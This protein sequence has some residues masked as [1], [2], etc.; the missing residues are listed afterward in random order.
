MDTDAQAEIAALKRKL[1]KLSERLGI[2]VDDSDENTIEEQVDEPAPQIARGT[3]DHTAEASTATA[4]LD[5]LPIPMPAP[6]PAP[7]QTEPLPDR[8]V[9]TLLRT[10]QMMTSKQL[11]NELHVPVEKVEVATRE[12]YPERLTNL[13]TVQHPRWYLRLGEECSPLALRQSV[14][15]LIRTAPRTL[16]DLV[17]ITGVRSDRVNGARQHLVRTGTHMINLGTRE[18]AL[19]YLPDPAQLKP[20][21]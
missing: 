12:L 10:K 3:S 21:R 8:I 2:S 11:A 7:K 19:W 9:A 17:D 4:I 13:G 20:A 14:E 15:Y 5:A 1:E 18:H 16:Q 6:R